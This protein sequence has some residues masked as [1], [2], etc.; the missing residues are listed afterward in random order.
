MVTRFMRDG[1]A[2]KARAVP[3]PVPTSKFACGGNSGIVLYCPGACFDCTE[4]RTADTVTL[5]WPSGRRCSRR[6]PG[7]TRTLDSHAPRLRRKLAA[8]SPRPWV[9]N[10]WG[11]GYRLVE[12]D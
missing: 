3:T 7:R 9:V 11:V 4:A 5:R 2:G 12:P 6:V 1:C 10:Q 8:V